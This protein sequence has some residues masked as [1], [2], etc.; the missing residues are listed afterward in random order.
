MD[1]DKE[2][3]YFERQAKTMD[4][5]DT[6]VIDGAPCKVDMSDACREHILS[7]QASRYVWLVCVPGLVWC[8]PWYVVG[9]MPVTFLAIAAL[10]RG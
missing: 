8:A 6:Y 1:R 10:L 7:S 4:I 3:G 9:C 2:K 5:I